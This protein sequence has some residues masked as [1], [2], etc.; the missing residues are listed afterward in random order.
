MTFSGSATNNNR[1]QLCLD[2]VIV[3]ILHRVSSGTDPAFAGEYAGC[4][5]SGHER[6]DEPQH[7]NGMHGE[8]G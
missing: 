8:D 3:N 2:A 1:V 7:D 5:T 4:D 6:S